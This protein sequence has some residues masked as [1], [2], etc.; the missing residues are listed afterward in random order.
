MATG[1][2]ASGLYREERASNLL[3]G[4]APFYDVYETADGRHLAVGALE[5]QFYDDLVRLLGIAGAV[6][7]RNDPA[8]HPEAAA[9]H[10]RR[11]PRPDPGRVGRGVRGLR[12]LRGSGDPPER[13]VLTIRTSRLGAPSSSATG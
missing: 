1:F 8:N 10:R 9:V 2:L 6:S 3:D 5:P 13:G 4:G 7:D 12:R 11:D